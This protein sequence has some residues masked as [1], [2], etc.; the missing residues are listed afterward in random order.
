MLAGCVAGHG[1]RPQPAIEGCRCIVYR[2]RRGQDTAVPMM[3]SFN[4]G[5]HADNNVD[6]QSSW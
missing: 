5:A 1:A 6:F 3:N 2:R 4:G